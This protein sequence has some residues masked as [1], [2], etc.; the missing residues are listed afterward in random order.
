M[1]EEQTTALPRECGGQGALIPVASLPNG[2]D[3]GT[4][5]CQ[6]FKCLSRAADVQKHL[7]E[8]RLELPV[9]PS[10]EPPKAAK[11]EPTPLPRACLLSRWTPGDAPEAC[12][13]AWERAVDVL[14]QSEGL[15]P[16]P[17]TLTKPLP[18]EC[19]YVRWL[20]GS[21]PKKC[22]AE[23]P[24]ALA[25]LIAPPVSEQPRYRNP[26]CNRAL[27]VPG[28]EPPECLQGLEKCLR[29]WELKQV[30]TVPVSQICTHVRSSDTANLMDDLAKCRQTLGKHTDPT[31][32]AGPSPRPSEEA[33]ERT[34]ERDRRDAE[35]ERHTRERQDSERRLREAHERERQTV[36]RTAAKAERE[37]AQRDREARER[38]LQ[39]A[40][41]E[42]EKARK[43]AEEARAKWFYGI[44]KE[45]GGI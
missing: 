7:E 5:K 29:T 1:P 9:I 2:L 36:E 40:R 30:E 10:G 44:P 27:F 43:A 17:L 33:H 22:R 35:A 24:R 37:A 16:K 20:D 26:R 15:L 34:R 39:R 42:E 32:G 31:E 11:L 38:E 14:L 41:K 21:E 8:H 13:G 45:A 4:A 28:T 23:V 19:T 18:R 6:P 3:L 12:K 25:E